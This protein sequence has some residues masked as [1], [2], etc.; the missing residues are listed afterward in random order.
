MTE[1]EWETDFARCLG[2]YLSG[3]A[4]AGQDKRGQPLHDDDF[5]LLF[6]AHH[7]DM[8]FRIPE[9]GDGAWTPVIDTSL[10]S[11]SP[12]AQSLRPGETYTMKCRAMAV[13]SRPA[14]GRPAP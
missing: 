14:H 7:E 1:A 3:I 9:I 13:L 6:N 8:D 2:M 10:P 12:E 4:I 11:G 5:L